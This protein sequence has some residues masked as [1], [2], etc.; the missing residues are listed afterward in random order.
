LVRGVPTGDLAMD[1][2]QVFGS[3]LYVGIGVRK[4]AGRPDCENPYT[5]TIARIADLD[6]IDYAGGA[7]YL[8]DTT[9]YRDPAPLD[10]KLRRYAYG[11]RNPFGLRVDGLGRVWISDNGASDCTT[12]SSCANFGTDTP[13][14]L[15]RDVP[16]G[17]KGEFPPAGYPGG[18]GATITRFA[19]LAMHAAVTG[20]AWIGSGPEAGHI[21]LAEYGATD[22]VL[23]VGR[24]VVRIDPATGAASPFITGFAGPTDIVADA[25]GRM[26]IADNAGSA[27][28]LLTPPGVLGVPAREPG[29]GSRIERVAPNPSSGDVTIEYSLPGPARVTLRVLDLE[30]RELARIDRG[31]EAAGRHS[32]SWRGA[33]RRPLPAGVYACRLE[34][35][36]GVAVRML[37]RL[38]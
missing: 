13:D 35:V 27:V 15:Y 19:T 32:M 18:G 6:Q 8:P 25:H 17:A 16:M 24:D 20:F 9:E 10:G 23:H 21:L 36:W 4:N 3:T 28:Y 34:T 30:G 7:N 5:G 26:L 38:E 14:L 2:L 33:A 29:P 11:V 31:V 22:T 1:Q 12:C 37:V